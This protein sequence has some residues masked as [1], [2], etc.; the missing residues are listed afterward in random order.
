MAW[1]AYVIECDVVYGSCLF[2]RTDLL[3]QISLIPEDYFLF[4][5]ETDWCYHAHTL[6]Y[7]NKSITT[8][9]V[10]HKGGASTDHFAGTGLLPYLYDRNRIVFTKKYLNKLQ[11]T[12]FAVSDFFKT[13]YQE[14]K[15]PRKLLRRLSRKYDGLRGKVNRKYSYIYVNRQK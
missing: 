14:R 9:C 1:Y 13:I 5:E 7:V 15:R 11:M 2:L 12:E 6:G 8:V 10:R 3:D 4:Y